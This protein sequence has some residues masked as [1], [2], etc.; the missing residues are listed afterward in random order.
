MP[1]CFRSVRFAACALVVATFSPAH[2][3]NELG[4]HT[5]AVIAFEL[6]SPSDQ[7][8]LVQILRQ[9]PRFDIDFVP[10]EDVPANS[11]AIVRWQ[12]GVAGY[13]PDIIRP[14]DEWT[15]PTWHYQL[16]ASQVLGDGTATEVPETPGPVSQQAT[17]ETRELYIAQAIELCRGVLADSGRLDADRAV[18]ICWLAH[19]VAD[20]HQPCHAGSLYAATVFPEGDRG[21]NSIPVKIGDES[22]T[23]HLYWDDLLGRLSESDDVRGQVEMLMGDPVLS[24]AS[25][26]SAGAADGLATERWLEESRLA[27]A[28]H[29]YTPEALVPVYAVIRGLTQRV[30]PFTPSDSYYRNG[31]AVVRLRIS[32]AGH[33][34]AQI[35]QMGLGAGDAEGAR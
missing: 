7:Q 14:L 31:N 5:A 19:L 15:R 13:W 22:T 26:M 30:A 28:R 24:L 34:L 8:S 17:L 11:E 6:L 25:E 12:V 10:R 21:A 4:H 29:V 9:H 35:W 3:F 20:A 27:S 2:G 33:R 18:A 1:A 23:L 16:G 32:Q